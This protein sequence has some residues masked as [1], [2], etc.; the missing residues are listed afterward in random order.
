V[1]LYRLHLS[2]FTFPFKNA[3]ISNSGKVKIDLADLNFGNERQDCLFTLSS[4]LRLPLLE[5]SS[6]GTANCTAFMP[7]SD[8]CTD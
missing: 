7:L 8:E 2:H 4:Q 6:S 5:V 3:R 1:T